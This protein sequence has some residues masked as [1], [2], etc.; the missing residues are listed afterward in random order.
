[1]T[2]VFKICNNPKCDIVITDY[3][4]DADEYIAE[5]VPEI[6]ARVSHKKNKFKYSETYTINIIE[7]HT[8]SESTIV[9]TSISD[10]CSY[11]DEEHYHIEDDGYYTIH[12]II[13]PSVKCIKED[14]QE[15]SD[16]EK[17][18]TI[19][20][21]D[22]YTIYNWATDTEVDPKVI[23]EVNTEG[24]TISRAD[25]DEFSI[26]HLWDCFIKLCKSIYSN[27]SFKCM[28]R[29]G[30]DDVLFRRDF[31]WMT[32]NVIKYYVELG[33]LLEAQRLLEEINYCGGLCNDTDMSKQSSSGCGCSKRA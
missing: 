32:I 24:T 4:Q 1:M 12:H 26:C 29:D 15:G 11:L 25:S 5:A 16:I 20:C 27:I 7:K 17:E 19:Y 2:P 33:Q 6:T 8:V 23:A 14:V 30:L 22:G 18:L 10:H 13:L 9:S 21:T 3:T 31:L 28:S